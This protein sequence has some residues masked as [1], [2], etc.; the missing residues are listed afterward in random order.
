MALTDQPSYFAAIDRWL[1]RIAAAVIRSIGNPTH[2]LAEWAVLG[3]GFGWGIWLL[4]FGWYARERPYSLLNA[5]SQILPTAVFAISVLGFAAR[6]Y[7]WALTR[8]AVCYV[9][10]LWLIGMA[11][12]V[13]V[14]ELASGA[15]PLFTVM[16]LTGL[17]EGLRHTGE[18]AR[19]RAKGDE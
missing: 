11:L 6:S 18:R 9:L 4:I 13:A 1:D 15:V 3:T 17:F 12:S 10:G 7:K 5:L 16:G 2:H 19:E 14:R 8:E